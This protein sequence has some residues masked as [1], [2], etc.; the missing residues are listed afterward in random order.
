MRILLVEDDTRAEIRRRG[1]EMLVPSVD[2]LVNCAGIT[3]DGTLKK[4]PGP[5]VVL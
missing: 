4:M 3:R 1:N 2:I 5:P